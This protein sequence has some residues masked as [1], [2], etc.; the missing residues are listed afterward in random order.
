MRPSSLPRSL[1]LLL[2]CGLGLSLLPAAA[3]AV[4]LGAAQGFTILGGSTVTNT[5]LTVLDGD[6]GVWPGA[7]ITGFPPGVVAGALHFGD[8]I[9]MAAHNDATAA[10]ASLAALVPTTTLSGTDLGGL[11]LTPGVYFFA[12]S[13]ALTGI[14]TLNAMGD[15]NAEFIFQ[16]GSTLTS[17]TGASVRTIGGADGCNVYWQ[18]GSSATLGT[19]TTFQGTI[20]AQASITLT[21][22]VTITD[23]RALALTG[24]VTLDTNRVASDCL[25]PAP[26]TGAL[27][28]AC[29]MGMGV[30]RRRVLGV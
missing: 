14:L 20:I 9:A 26:G 8:P 22:G 6:I 30:R 10:Y 13:A 29:G 19:L 24:A 15:P 16:I 17:A 21:T 28:L 11:I 25:I 5:G 1:S 12:S 4:P 2:S 23:G 18:V 3:R 7:A 27:L